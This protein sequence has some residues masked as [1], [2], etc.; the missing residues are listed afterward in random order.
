MTAWALA[1]GALL[2]LLGPCAYACVRGSVLL[3][4]AALELA[5]VV[6]TLLVIALARGLGRSSYMDLAL[7]LALLS[8]GSAIVYTRLIERWL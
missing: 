1:A 3:R 4:L 7:M 5:T 2:L 8:F 6:V